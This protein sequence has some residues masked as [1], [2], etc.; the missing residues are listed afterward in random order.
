MTTETA[1]QQAAF[2]ASAAA[3]DAVAPAARVAPV[4]PRSRLLPAGAEH[5]TRGELAREFLRWPTLLWLPIEVT[6]LVLVGL[7]SPLAAV[8]VALLIST[9]ATVNATRRA[10]GKKAS[11]NA[12]SFMAELPKP[13]P[14]S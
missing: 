4:V 1:L 12:A 11:P 8:P 7:A 10:A 13:R 2:A 6:M 5:V 14:A 3:T 9:V